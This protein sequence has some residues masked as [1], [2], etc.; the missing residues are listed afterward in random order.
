MKFYIQ[1]EVLNS[2]EN[3]FSYSV[4]SACRSNLHLNCHI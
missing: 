1:N 2:K 4:T 3:H